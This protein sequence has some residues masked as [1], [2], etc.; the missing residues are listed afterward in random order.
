MKRGDNLSKKD[1]SN[2]TKD[3]TK[4]KVIAF[5]FYTSPKVANQIEELYHQMKLQQNLQK[6]K[7]RVTRS[8]II[9]M[10]LERTFG[11]TTKAPK[12]IERRKSNLLC[13]DIKEE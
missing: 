4:E 11:D 13:F 7:R 3:E 8:A 10:A 12:G 2:N 5:T 9:S 6:G 1:P